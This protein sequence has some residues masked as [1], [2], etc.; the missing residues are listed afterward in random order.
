MPVVAQASDPTSIGF[1]PRKGWGAVFIPR[2]S[3]Y[4]R[5]PIC[6]PAGILAFQMVFRRGQDCLIAHL[7]VTCNCAAP[8]CDWQF[9]CSQEIVPYEAKRCALDTAVERNCSTPQPGNFRRWVAGIVTVY[10]LLHRRYFCGLCVTGM[11]TSRA[12]LALLRFRR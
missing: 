8:A 4:Y 10:E 11:A 12:Y 2:G 5:R 1:I 3:S 6:Q 7:S 9:R